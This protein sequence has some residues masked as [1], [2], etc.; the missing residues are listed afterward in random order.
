[1]KYWKPIGGVVAVLLVLAALLP[2][3]ISLNDHIPRIEAEASASLQQ[4]VKIQ[5]L[6][7]ALLPVPH[8]TIVGIAIGKTADISLGK[9]VL[10]PDVHSLLDA[11]KILKSVEIDS[12]LL[13]RKG[14]DGMA[15]WARTNAAKPPSG[16]SVRIENIH[17]DKVVVRLEKMEFGPF[18]ARVQ[19]DTAGAPKE[20]SLATKDGKLKARITPDKAGYLID[21]GATAWTLPAGP[22]LVFD[23]LVMKG[24]ATAN[25][26]RLGEVKAKLYGG[27]VLGKMDIDWQKGLKISGNFDIRELEMRQLAPLL[28]PGTR[29]SGRLTAKPSFSATAAST[30]QLAHALRLDTAFQ[31][32]NGVLHGVDIQHAATHLIKQGTTGGETR[33]D[34]LSGHLVVAQGSQHFTQLEIASGALAADGKVSITPK[35]ELSGR[36]NAQIKA[37]GTSAKVPLNVGGTISSPLLYPTGGT[38][39]G[40]AIGTVI[41]GP[42]MGTSVGAK[43]G[44]W[45]ERLFDK[46]KPKAPQKK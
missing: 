10:T 28:S 26:L 42:G 15:A 1:M 16:T 37:V 19:L 24:V 27:T 40:A 41:L 45:A 11:T 36:I 34:H 44:G 46:D 31:V 4:P 5:S 25:D 21:V 2:L 22:P 3:F 12:L 9:V 20:A 18:E 33:F 17:L 29:V 32:R 30:E 43:V 13:T 23:E 39:A 14:I 8:L 7:F 35:K 6:K 38:V